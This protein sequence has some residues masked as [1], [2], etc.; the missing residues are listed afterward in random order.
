M[1]KD[2]KNKPLVEAIFELRWSLDKTP[3]GTT[4]DPHYKILIGRL[5]DKLRDEYPFHEQLA[6]ATVPDEIASY[7]LQHRFRKSKG[8]WP[9]IQIGPGIIAVNDTQGYHW[10][11]FSKRITKAVDALFEVYPGSKLIVDRLLLRYINAID[12]QFGKISVLDFLKEKMKTQIALPQSLFK[13]V[14]VQSLPS[15]IDLRFAF[16]SL[17]PEGIVR[18]RFA[19]GKSNDSEVLMWEIM[20]DSHPKKVLTVL[21]EIDQWLTNAHNLAE[22]WFFKL[23]EG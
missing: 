19:R 16:N 12:F 2:L 11:D 8:Q 17:E 3:H 21:Q 10:I 13:D 14:K 7:V 18:L 4:V 22:D 5:Y 9:L 6:A 15:G 23:I 1:N 20:V